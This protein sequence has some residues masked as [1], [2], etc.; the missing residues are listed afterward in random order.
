MRGP[1]RPAARALAEACAWTA[2]IAAGLWVSLHQALA[3]WQADPD[4][5][6]PVALWRGV[7]EHGLGFVAT[8]GHTEDNWVFSLLPLASAAYEAFGSGPRVAVLI[9]WAVFIVSVGL[10]AA[11]AGRLAGWRAAA[12]LGATLLF[13]NYYALGPMGFL[14]YP[15]SHD[16]SMA[17]G[18]ATLLLAVC[19]VEREA[20]APGL[21]AGVLVLANAVSDPWASAAISAPL[22]ATSGI[23]AVLHRRTRLGRAALA[24]FVACGLG[25]WAAY[26]HPLGLF[27]F[28]P[29]GHFHPGGLEALAANLGY[30]YRALAVMFEIVP[31]ASLESPL[32][33]GASFTALVL[34]VA[35]AAILA[36][37]GLRRA[38]PARQLVTGVAVL[39]LGAVT[40]L[41][42]AGPAN[43]GLYV[44][45]FFAN[46][47]FLG[48]LLAVV[49]ATAFAWPSWP[50]AAYA[51][52]FVLSGL[53][54]TP[55]TWTGPLA[56]SGVRETEALGAFLQAH[57]LSYGYGP[58]W[59]VRALAMADLTGGAVTVRP[60][61]FQNG[62]VEPRP[63]ESSRLWYR[64]GAEPPANRP[65]LVV[66]RGPEACAA[67]DLC[68]AMARRQFGEPAERL[69]RGDALILVWDR[70][71]AALIGAR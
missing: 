11:I 40:L 9:G 28:L 58:Y 22:I 52:L 61:I 17:W 60:V 18:L 7:R 38:G 69:V 5:Y 31:G 49:A 67:E 70:P 25:A 20:I 36:L 44:G 30:G 14:A 32:V 3:A 19:A 35:A 4:I 50:I 57:R 26:S 71:I 41:Y 59:G 15:V 23:L 39:S 10:A 62:R 64:L 46:L 2:L 54:M 65:F 51:V 42:L 48:P 55:R 27:R 13:A 24:L 37:L 6:V 29:R 1:G 45:R 16:V 34:F 33:I 47:Y 21:A 53:A 56:P 68:E 12:V 43:Q 8:W 63:A 66:Q